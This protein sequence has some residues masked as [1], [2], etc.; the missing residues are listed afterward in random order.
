MQRWHPSACKCNARTAEERLNSC[1]L[2]HI[3]ERLERHVVHRD[4]DRASPVAARRRQLSAPSDPSDALLALPEERRRFGQAADAIVAPDLF[5]VAQ[6]VEEGAEVGRIA[7]EE[8]EQERE[9]RD[10]ARMA[11]VVRLVWDASV[12]CSG[13]L[14]AG[15]A[16]RHRKAKRR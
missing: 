2:T 1:D 11:D 13:V 6:E 9:E 5:R 15:R 10:V 7:R 3:V 12:E 4:P 14:I 8:A 16:R